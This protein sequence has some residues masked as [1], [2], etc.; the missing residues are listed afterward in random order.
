M[1]VLG[2]VRS[3]AGALRAPGL[4]RWLRVIGPAWV[5][6]LADVDAPSVITAGTGGTEAGY[7]LLVPLFALVP[8]LF[9]V[10]EMTARLALAT[11]KG[12]AEL[13]RLR[14]G[15]RW[16]AV[17]VGGMA[18]INFVAYVAEFAGIALGASILGISGPL[19]IVAGL[20]VHAAIVLTGGY[21]AFERLALILSLALFSFVVL[22]VV[23]H[24]DLG[25]LASDLSPVPG[26][27]PH[28]YFA[29]VVAMVGA[30]VMP[31]M[32]FYQQSASVDKKLDCGDLRGSRIE[33]LL[34]ALASQ[35]LMAAIVIASAAAMELAPPLAKLPANVADLPEGLARLA[36][37]GPGLL[38]ATGLIGSAL[39]ALI[40]VSLSAAWGIGE[41]MGWPHSLN[42]RPNEARRFYAV[43]FAEVIPAALVA[44]LSP[45]LV[46]LCLGAMV[47]N[48]VVLALPLTFLV[49][50]T[51]DRDLLGD[52]A[53]SRR[54][55]VVMWGL[56]VILLAAGVV[57]MAQ[58]LLGG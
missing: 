30:S 14:F 34:G 12:H 53:N 27:I 45:D 6:M 47:F 20:A 54:H 49:R 23:G 18:V 11:G 52:L 32:L 4:L 51:S 7:A 46:R 10:Q 58:F 3:L 35:A 28:D 9:L 2:G 44:L 26:D 57:G 22:A 1:T 48:V 31:W 37:G 13:V 16:A 43:Y 56:T 15:G 25:H 55:A 41:L 39:L 21:T 33:T 50:L 8:V 5:V 29:L 42:L 19:A 24:P 36:S 40:V 38:I 17:S